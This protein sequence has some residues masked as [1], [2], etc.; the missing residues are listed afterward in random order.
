MTSFRRTS[1]LLA[2]L[3]F[4]GCAEQVDV[5]FS[6]RD[7]D[8]AKSCGTAMN[9]ARMG[10]YIITTYTTKSDDCAEGPIQVVEEQCVQSAPVP[11]VA[12]ELDTMVVESGLRMEN[13]DPGRRTCVRA[14]ALYEGMSTGPAQVVPCKTDWRQRVVEDTRD[15]MAD[16]LRLCSRTALPVSGNTPSVKLIDTYCAR[17]DGSTEF[18]LARD[19]AILE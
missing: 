11:V 17:A 2:L 6:V 19:C 5:T 1:P 15:G 18:A 13:W 7:M 16:V 3:L 10:S 14:I 9:T 8:K 12:E 4:A